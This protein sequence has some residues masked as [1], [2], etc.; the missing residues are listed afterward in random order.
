MEVS[1]QTWNAFRDAKCGVV[2]S[3]QKLIVFDTPNGDFLFLYPKQNK[4]TLNKCVGRDSLNN[5]PIINTEI[6]EA[7]F[8]VEDHIQLTKALSIIKKLKK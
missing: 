7:E 6:N 3:T 8:F 5:M 2:R 1:T 4:M